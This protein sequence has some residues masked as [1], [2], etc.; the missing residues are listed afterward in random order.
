MAEQ[1]AESLIVRAA[2]RARQASPPA[3]ESVS[4]RQEAPAACSGSPAFGRSPAQRP[5]FPERPPRRLEPSPA[6]SRVLTHVSV[7]IPTCN[8]AQRIALTVQRVL[9]QGPIG[10]LWLVDDG[11]EDDTADLAQAA[12]ATSHVSGELA[13]MTSTPTPPGWERESWLLQ[14]GLRQVATARVAIVHPGV[15]LLPYA[16]ASLTALCTR[17]ELAWAEAKTADQAPVV[18]A[19]ALLGRTIKPRLALAE[20]SAL[21]AVGG[22]A[23]AKEPPV[24]R[25]LVKS[26]F[27]VWRGRTTVARTTFA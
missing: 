25:R 9:E 17:F 5:L 3:Q 26:G 11:S 6:A 10:P 20:T 4:N 24:A 23:R 27:R 22:F 21:H 19:G 13:V 12:A 14:Q 2:A 8:D 15:E 7:L 18:S 1:H 16:L